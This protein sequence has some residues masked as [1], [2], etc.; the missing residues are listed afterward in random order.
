MNVDPTDL[1]Y[2]LVPPKP[3]KRGGTPRESEY[4]GSHDSLSVLLIHDHSAYC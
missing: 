2:R 3:N 4:G 1:R